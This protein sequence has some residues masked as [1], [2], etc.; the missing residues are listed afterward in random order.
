MRSVRTR[1]AVIAAVTTAIAVSVAGFLL[2]SQLSSSLDREINESLE[3]QLINFEAAIET[4]ADF[5]TVQV[6][7]DPETLLIVLDSDGFA[8]LANDEGVDG[9]EVAEALPLTT[10]AF[11][12]VNFA[13][14][15]LMT[16]TETTEPGSLRA[17]YIEV[18]LDDQRVDE[19]FFVV[20]ARSSAP[21]DR[22]VA[23]LRNTLL[24]GLPLLVAFVAA[25]AWW[26]TGR[27][28]NPV[29]QMRREVDEIS[30][31]DLERR[32]SEPTATDEIGELARTMNRMLGRLEQSQKTQEQFVSD[33]AHEL[34]TPLASIA[35]QID[36]DDA[37][38]GSAD[39]TATAS[40]V[41]SEVTRLQS[42][43]DGLLMSARNQE[44]HE[45]SKQSLVDLDVVAG[46]A[47][48]RVELPGHVQLDQRGIG[49]G[50]VRGD[51]VVLASV[52]DNLLANAGRHARH[53]VAINVGTDTAGV[54]LTVDDDG[55]GIAA[56]DR[57]RIFDRF[58]RLDEARSRD[59]GGSGLG[60]ALARETAS[61]HGGTLHM[62]DSPLGGARFV[63]WLPHPSFG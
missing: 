22:T 52:V 15:S 5:E 8:P 13:D 62:D 17:A 12:E 55:A 60:L 42:L 9:V 19:E 29:D 4:Y 44:Q 58:V 35:A 53:H 40:N 6:P 30:S 48:G 49:A 32:V 2:L 20:V 61:R 14:I 59:A 24:V 43:I 33:A 36:V 21:A 38:P 7:S 16:P 57:D 27:S 54:W 45:P 56:I 18:F 50:T 39:R 46:S 41:R 34:R 51:E 1:I 31:T 11:D 37:H 28:L 25:L 47:A 3:R 23:G 26:L 10:V 63:L